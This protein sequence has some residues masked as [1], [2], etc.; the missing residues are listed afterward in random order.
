ML[1]TPGHAIVMKEGLVQKRKP[2]EIIVLPGEHE[3]AGD[4]RTLLESQREPATDTEVR[5]NIHELR[6][7]TE[8]YLPEKE[9]RRLQGLLS[10]GFLIS[11]LKDYIDNYHDIVRAESGEDPDAA[12]E[13]EDR[14]T[15][16]DQFPWIKKVIPWVPLVENGS[17]VDSSGRTFHGYISSSAPQ[18]DKL[19]VRIM[20]ECWHLSIQ[21]LNSGLGEIQVKVEPMVFALLMREPP[22]PLLLF[23]VV[24]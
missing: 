17:V 2:R 11:Q 5:A 18:R 19:A 12:A 9:F 23:L 10:E 8:K 13:E 1:G 6:P 7:S 22:L 4:I 14:D 3:P 15:A 16:L 20:R 21:E 24:S